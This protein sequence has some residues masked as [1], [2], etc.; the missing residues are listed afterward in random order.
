ML[1]D[2]GQPLPFDRY[3]ANYLLFWFMLIVGISRERDWKQILTCL[4]S[5]WALFLQ[6]Y[7]CKQLI[8]QEACECYY[9]EKD[10][11]LVLGERKDYYS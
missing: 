11:P 8:L 10:P 6:F 7:H 5:G 4:M 3:L 2:G 1:M 9:I